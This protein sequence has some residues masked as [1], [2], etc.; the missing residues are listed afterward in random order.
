MLEQRTRLSFRHDGPD[1]TPRFVAQWL[2]GVAE[3]QTLR[4]DSY[5]LGGAI[6][7]FERAF[8]D[9]VGKEKAIFMP[10]GTLANHLAIR[11]LARGRNRI[12]VQER[13]HIYND[14]GDCLQKL[15]GF[16][17][18]PLGKGRATFTLD[19]V[20]EAI[21]V[22]A[23]ARVRVDPGVLVIETP[24][25]RLYGARFDHAEMVRICAFCRKHGI[26]LHLDGARIFIESAYTGIPVR[27][28]TALFD[29]VYVSLYKTFG[30]PCGAVLAGPAQLLDG[31]HHERRMFGGALN[32]GWMFTA[33]AQDSLVGSPVRFHEVVAASERFKARLR[34]LPGL[35][36]TDVPDG[37]NICRLDL[38]RDAEGFRTRLEASGVG[39]PDP[40][41]GGFYLRM[42]ESLLGEA[43]ESVVER[44]RQALQG[45]GA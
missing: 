21:E 10:T 26:G 20:R 36:V 6:A 24:V 2:R 40:E 14:S 32:Q 7:D 37:T 18:V 27:D 8:A 22:A 4:A 42:N 30:T 3:A 25:R 13:G 23:H 11:A 34:G 31:L 41:A 29:T 44:F 33:M 9:L 43:L 12:L 45:D 38:D 19:E 1:L 39:L 15:S 35:T 17:L 28:Y 16:N 5:L